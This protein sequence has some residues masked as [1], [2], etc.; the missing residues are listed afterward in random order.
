VEISTNGAVIGGQKLVFCVCRDISEKKAMERQIREMAIRDPLTDLYNRRYIFERLD[1]MEA[2]YSRTKRD[3]C[4]SIIDLDNFKTVN[5]SYGHVVGDQVLKEF[6]GTLAASVRRCDLV[7]RYGGEEFIILSRNTGPAET[8]MMVERL[9]DTVR[10]KPMMF[11]DREISP[12]FCCGI[13]GRSELPPEDS[14]V[15]A[16]LRRADARLYSA[17]DAGRNCYVYSEAAAR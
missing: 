13:A 7:G 5:D 9:M 12:T 17:K 6:A 4:I 11:N 3:F 8:I 1:E 15:D 10:N 16:L 14:S 2:E